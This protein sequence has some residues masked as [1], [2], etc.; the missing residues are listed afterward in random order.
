MAP[1]AAGSQGQIA[2]QFEAF[3]RKTYG[4]T[5]RGASCPA[6]A[7]LAA[8]EKSRDVELDDLRDPRYAKIRIL[9]VDWVPTVP[10]PVPTA[11]PKPTASAP[12]PTAQ[13]KFEQAMAAERPASTGTPPAPK[14]STAPSVRAT[15]PIHHAAIAPT[16]KYSYCIAVGGPRRS[17]EQ[18]AYVSQVFVLRGV[19]TEY[20]FGAF[21]RSVHPQDAF[22]TI[23]CSY[24]QS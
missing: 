18:H 8:T 20:A 6:D 3:V 5:T 24:P 1:I 16:E 15:T 21:V 11:A 19:N 7:S 4:R 13:Q 2:D 14:P 10:A 12:P 23:R 9:E 22:G 17:T